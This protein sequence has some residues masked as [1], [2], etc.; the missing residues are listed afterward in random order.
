M[1]ETIVESLRRV[2]RFAEAWGRPYAVIGGIAVVARARPRTTQD[3]DLIIVATPDE[4]ER[5]LQLARSS[6]F[7]FD[8]EETRAFLPGGLVR[9]WAPPSRAEGFGLDLLFADSDFLRQ[10]IERAS[11]LDLGGV[12]MPIATVEDLLLLKLEAHRLEDLDDIIAIR[13]A[14]EGALDLG[15]LRSQ[16]QT[17]GVETRLELY[18]SGEPTPGPG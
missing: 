17:L 11:A 2:Q 6:G 15:Y 7:D 14:F 9:L 16:A 10:V 5:L 12:Q 13:D 3:V 1:T 4:G 18:L 8:E